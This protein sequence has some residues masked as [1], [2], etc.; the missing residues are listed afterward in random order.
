MKELDK[1]VNRFESAIMDDDDQ[2]EEEEDIARG[3]CRTKQKVP[4]KLKFDWIIASSQ[5]EDADSGLS[6]TNQVDRIS[7]D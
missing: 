5:E 6:A 3:I 2:G 1:E 4:I 7:E